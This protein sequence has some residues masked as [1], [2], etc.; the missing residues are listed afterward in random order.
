MKKRILLLFIIIIIAVAAVLFFLFYSY[1]TTKARAQYN[2]SPQVEKS[3]SQEE[4]LQKIKMRTEV[5]KYEI[6]LTKLGSKAQIDVEDLEEDWNV[7][8]YEI[9]VAGDSSHTA[10]FGWYRVNKKTGNIIKDL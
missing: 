6:E 1:T 5:Q 4:A 3:I 10:T 2:P 9:V 7:H 8:V